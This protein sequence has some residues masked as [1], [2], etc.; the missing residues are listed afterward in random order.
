FM[1]QTQFHETKATVSRLEA[2]SMEVALNI[3]ET[4]EK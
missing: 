2:E 4:L 1:D 3:A